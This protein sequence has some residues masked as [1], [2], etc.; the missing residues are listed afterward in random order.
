MSNVTVGI[1]DQ[2]VCSIPDIL[3]TFALGS[4]V[5]ICLYDPQTKVSGMA[6]IM[7]PSSREISGSQANIMKFADTSI[8]ELISQMERAGASRRRI[9]AK[10]AGGAQMFATQSERFNIGERNIIAVKQVLN[11]LKIPLLAS[12]TG[13]NYGRTVYFH[14]ENGIMEVKA[15]TKGIKTY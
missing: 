11:D 5:G 12:D 15:A 1:S 2:K 6:H 14:S 4:C 7:L 13:L 3:V 8:P 9:T 10:I